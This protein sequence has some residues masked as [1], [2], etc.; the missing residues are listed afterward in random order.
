M[1]LTWV[2]EDRHRCATVWHHKRPSGLARTTCVIAHKMFE[3]LF[4]IS[5]QWE[6]R[7]QQ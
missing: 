6:T 1:N 2:Q 3:I 5:A 4:V 7:R